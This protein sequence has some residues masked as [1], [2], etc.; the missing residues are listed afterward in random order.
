MICSL[1]ADSCAVFRMSSTGVGLAA[2]EGIAI[3]VAGTL[4]S[5]KTI[6]RYVRI[7]EFW[8]AAA[9]PNF[10]AA[11]LRALSNSENRALWDGVVRDEQTVPEEDLS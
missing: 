8:Q 10:F 7:V 2:F 11:G 5:R 1:A 4:A 3:G 6:R 9:V